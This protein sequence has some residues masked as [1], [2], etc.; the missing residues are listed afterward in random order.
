V[1]HDLRLGP[2]LGEVAAPVELAEGRLMPRRPPC[3]KYGCQQPAIAE[4]YIIWTDGH[5]TYNVW[6]TCYDHQ[7][8]IQFNLVSGA[9][10]GGVRPKSFHTK[11]LEQETLW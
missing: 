9:W 4:Y 1:R 10:S 11:F 2:R 3:D 8:E 6:R 7:T 5:T